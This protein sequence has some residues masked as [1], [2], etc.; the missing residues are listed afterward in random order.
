MFN[1]QKVGEDH[2]FQFSQLHY[3]M[4]NVKIS[5]LLPHIF[6]ASSYRFRDL[7]F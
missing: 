2:G 6:C 7:K 4:A 1:L 3:S 5:K